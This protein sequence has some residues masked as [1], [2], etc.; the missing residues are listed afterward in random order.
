MVHKNGSPGVPIVV[1]WLTNLTGIHEDAGLI[2]GIAGSCGGVGN[3]CGLAPALLW[4]WCRP[5]ATAPI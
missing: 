2:P 5:A 1:L 3:K 4:L